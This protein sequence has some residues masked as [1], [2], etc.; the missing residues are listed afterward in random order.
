[1]RKLIIIATSVLFYI[2]ILRFL[3][4]ISIL[5]N[6]LFYLTKEFY[7]GCVIIMVLVVIAR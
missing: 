4:M 6:P 5:S 2:L 7:I 3:S 1:M